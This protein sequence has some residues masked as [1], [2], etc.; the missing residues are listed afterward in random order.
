MERL[1]SSIEGSIENERGW[2]GRRLFTESN[3]KP[4]LVNPRFGGVLNLERLIVSF[5]LFRNHDALSRLKKVSN[6][7]RFFK[8]S[9]YFT[10]VQLIVPIKEPTR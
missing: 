2:N 3:S 5:S 1:S 4:L 6:L 7:D 10:C 8:H 9:L